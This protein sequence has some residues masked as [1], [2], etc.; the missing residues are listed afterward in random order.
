MCEKEVAIKQYNWKGKVTA[1]RQNNSWIP[2]GGGGHLSREIEER[3]RQGTCMLL[4]PDISLVY[5][6]YGDN[7]EWRGYLWGGMFVPND[8]AND[9]FQLIKLRIASGICQVEQ[10]P[11]AEALNGKRVTEFIIGIYFDS[12]WLSIKKEIKA[13]VNYNLGSP[14]LIRIM[15]VSEIYIVGELLRLKKLF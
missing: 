5:E 15:Y 3:I 13:T 4:E 10:E 14:T 1:Y 8:E 6:V 9:L 12:Q 7:Q 2:A 11:K